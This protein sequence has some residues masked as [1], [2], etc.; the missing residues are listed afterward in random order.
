MKPANL[1]RRSTRSPLGRGLVLLAGLFCAIT[2]AWSGEVR[3]EYDGLGRLVSVAYFDGT[4]IEYEYDKSGNIVRERRYHD[5]S[6]ADA[7]EDGIPNVEDNCPLVANP[8]QTDADDDGPG[9]PCDNCPLAT[10]PDQA[11]LDGDGDG[12]ACDACTDSDGDGWGDPGIPGNTCDEDNCAQID[13]DQTDTDQDGVGDACDNCPETS[14]PDQ[15]DLD[16][17]GVGDACDLPCGAPV[18]SDMVAWWPGEDDGEEWIS[19]GDPTLV[20][21]AELADGFIGKAFHFDGGGERVDLPPGTLTG[22]TDLTIEFWVKTLDDVAAF[23][24]AAESDSEDNEL[25]IYLSG[26]DIR[27]S[28]QQEQK[29][30]ADLGE[31]PVNDGEWHHLALTRLGATGTLYIDGESVKSAG[32]FPTGALSVGAGGLVLGQEQDDLAGNFDTNQALIGAIDELSLYSRALSPFEIGVI[33]DARDLGKC[34]ESGDSDHDGEPD[35]RD[36]CPDVPNPD[37]AADFDRDGLGDACDS[38]PLEGE[39]LCIA[40]SAWLLSRA[41][42]LTFND[43]LGAHLNPKFTPEAASYPR[44]C[45]VYVGRYDDSPEAGGLF[46]LEDDGTQKTCWDDWWYAGGPWDPNHRVSGVT[47]EPGG[48]VWTTSVIDEG[49]LGKWYYD[50]TSSDPRFHT[51]FI[52]KSEVFQGAS[53]NRLGDDPAG[54]AFAPSDYTGRVIRPGRGLVVDRGYASQ[55]EIREIDPNSNPMTTTLLADPKGEDGELWDPID[56]A[57]GSSKVWVVDQLKDRVYEFT[58]EFRVV[59]LGLDPALDSPRAVAVDPLTED[60]FVAHATADDSRVARVDP[61]TLIVSNVITGLSNVSWSGVDVSADG[62]RL[63]V[64]DRRSP[65]GW[66]YVFDLDRDRDGV[67][68]P[69]DNCPLTYND[70]TD[71]DADGHGDACDNCDE[72]HNPDQADFDGDGPGDACDDDGDGDGVPDVLDCDDHNPYCWGGCPDS[73]GDGFCEEADDTPGFVSPDCDD[74]AATCIADCTTDLDGDGLRDCEDSCV[75]VDVDGFGSPGGGGHDCIADCDDTSAACALDCQTDDDADNLPDCKDPCIDLDRDGYGQPGSSGCEIDCD[76]SS[77]RCTDDCATDTDEDT[78]A[79][80]LDT[81]PTL[82]NHDQADA[83]GDGLGDACDS[84]TDTDADGLGDPGFPGNTSCAIDYCPDDPDNDLDGDGVCANEDNCPR[85]HDVTRADSD[86]DGIGDVCDACPFDP[87]DNPVGNSGPCILEPGWHLSRAIEFDNPQAAHYNPRDGSLYVGRSGADN[88]GNIY[89]V[90]PDGTQS[91][92]SRLSE[93]PRPAGLVV[94]VVDRDGDG[95]VEGDIYFTDAYSGTIWR[96]DYQHA[97]DPLSTEQAQAWIDGFHDDGDYDPIG[98]AIAPA[99]HVGSILEPGEALVVDIGVG[100]DPFDGIFGWEPGTGSP[101]GVFWDVQA[102]IENLYRWVDVAIGADRVWLVD[103]RSGT[104]RIF[105]LTGYRRSSDARGGLAQLETLA[106]LWDPAGLAYDSRTGDLLVLDRGGEARQGRLLRVDPDNGRVTEIVVGL[107]LNGP[108]ERAGVDVSPEGD[109]IFIT[110]NH[111]PQ[112]DGGEGRIYVLTLD[113]DGDGIRDGQDNC[114]SVINRDQSDETAEGEDRE[115]GTADDDPALFGDDATCGTAD[116]LSGDGV[117]SVC[118]NCSDVTNP[119]QSDCD[120]DGIGDACDGTYFDEPSLD[121]DEDGIED[122]CDNCPYESNVVQADV[123]RDGAGDACDELYLR[124]FYPF[125]GDDLESALTDAS[126]FDNDAYRLGGNVSF[127]AAGF[128]GRGA[129]FDGVGD[130]I[131]IP[132]HLRPAGS[133]AVTIGAWVQPER[134]DATET[135]FSHDDGGWMGRALIIQEPASVSSF[136]EYAAHDGTG[137]SL[138]SGRDVWPGWAFVAVTYDGAET[139][140]YVHKDGWHNVR[141]SVDQTVS[142]ERFARLGMKPNPTDDFFEGTLDNVFIYYNALTEEQ[143]LAIQA[144]G[145][146]AILQPTVDSDGD[147]T[148]DAFDSCPNNAESWERP[149]EVLHL[150]L[151]QAIA[152]GATIL[153]WDAPV[154]PGGSSVIYE[155]LRSDDPA[156]FTDSFC[157]ESADASA[158]ISQDLE[159]PALGQAWFYLVRGQDHCGHSGNCGTDSTGSYRVVRGCP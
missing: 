76:D 25:L 113:L 91:D 72:I 131:D 56:V 75:D 1:F 78:F 148:P 134:D 126:G 10:N 108:T 54:L 107:V 151:E 63:V 122:R 115:C 7:D 19:R 123:D 93:A 121:T 87:N 26:T 96:I 153:N 156:D 67:R 94:D 66:V 140:L 64:T 8:A 92:V 90:E 9:D 102:R 129:I 83:D 143:V 50:T 30:I 39:P 159:V 120:G 47:V 77:D 117:G 2:L 34:T 68:D 70:Q 5:D 146:A 43:P 16:D 32:G 3:Y 52:D 112:P 48:K 58:A 158:T 18:P 100:T 128:E 139:K 73:D 20:N 110:D 65:Y 149:G 38:C 142:G 118:D 61:Q 15:V 17:D 81:C 31:D 44:K 74:D 6:V 51:W 130:F 46:C 27:V 138:R 141:T 12:D 71:T 127:E 59:A 104:G 155:T 53:D 135:V 109:R 24:S 136:S 125:E 119:G 45:L 11:D 21:G 57:I 154:K 133:G 103:E 152:A 137:T 40:E 150:R 37:Q 62:G 114:P 35:Y 13:N 55:E 101:P 49:W 36:N 60:L 106:P 86:G 28:I 99:D 42:E 97:Q 23:V 98:M 89:R 82:V 144:G 29:L 105:E 147:A 33:A 69:E 41:F 84:C 14:N 88:T 116:D 79:D 111:A 80:C 145:S 157:V 124:A 132:V 85:G 22:L 95:E 4:V